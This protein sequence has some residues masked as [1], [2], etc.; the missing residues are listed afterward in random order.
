MLSRARRRVVA[1][2]ALMALAGCAGPVNPR[3]AEYGDGGYRFANVR[4]DGPGHE[5]FVILAFS[6]GGTRAAAFSY[7]VLEGLQAVTYQPAAGSARTLLEDVD[8]ISSVSGGSFT[9]AHYALFGTDGF[10]RFE[11]DFLYQDIQTKLILRALAP[12][13]WIKLARS[14]YSRI[15]LAA[16][17]YD[18]TIFAGATFDTLLRQ[19][20]GRPY[21][22]LNATDM[23]LGARFE[24]TQ[25]QFDLLCSDLSRLPVARAVAASS[26]FP[27]LLSP[28]TLHNYEGG[29]CQAYRQ[30]AWLT[31]A[32]ESAGEPRRLALAR[33]LISY[34]RD[35]KSRPY[36]HLL[37]GGLSD[38]IGL[39]G[40]YVALSG[41]DSAWS[42]FSKINE[43]KIRRVLVITANARTG[44]DPGWDTR[45]SPPGLSGVLGLVT[46]GP[47]GNYSFETVQ[48]ITEHFRRLNADLESLG[49]CERLAKAQCPAFSL[50]FEPAAE[51]EFH[52]VELSFDKV[53]DDPAL[54]SCLEG[55]ATSFA[56][57][58]AQVTLLRQVAQRLLLGSPDFQAAMKRIAPGW[59]PAP[60]PIDAALIR[61]A[62][63]AR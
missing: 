54:Q 11:D 33:N 58:R 57:P 14:D 44:R 63:A 48:L 41:Q 5:L 24:F 62:C 60:A 43:R 46:T 1:L 21:V 22:L 20:R 4:G 12:W 53:T 8:V 28:L 40:P 38:N 15:D 59:Q 45:E 42:I 31:S 9:A 6:G 32:L 13:N 55:L 50:P 27:I 30:P 25:D 61:D 47:M 23:T 2:G 35:V 16:D 34:R 52:A 3:L 29:P 39:R 10:K 37:D 17:L 49:A 36:V 19:S 7:G 56:L 18:E 26:A 51:V